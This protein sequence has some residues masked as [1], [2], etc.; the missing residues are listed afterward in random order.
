M[1]LYVKHLV[2]F[3]RASLISLLFGACWVVTF[4]AFDAYAEA[5]LLKYRSDFFFDIVL[6]FLSGLAGAFLFYITML[7]I[8]KLSA[9][10]TKS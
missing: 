7:L 5:Y 6:F 9:L 1:N 3:L 10:V 8:G 2:T 4:Y